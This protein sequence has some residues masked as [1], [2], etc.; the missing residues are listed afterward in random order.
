MNLGGSKQRQV[1]G[2]FQHGNKF[3]RSLRRDEI[4]D[5]LRKH[6][7][8]MKETRRVHVQARLDMNLFC[9]RRD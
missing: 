8:L 4:H 5:C 7:L 2:C 9:V 3:P 6:L 1:A